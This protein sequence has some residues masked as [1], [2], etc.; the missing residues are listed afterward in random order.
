M[1]LSQMKIDEFLDRLASQAPTPGGGSVAALTGALAAGLGH[2]ACALTLGKPKFAAV[3][4]QLRLFAQRLARAGANLREL[5]DEDA[6]AYELLRAALSL[7]KGD[8]QRPERVQAAAWVAGTVPLETA[9]FCARVL[10]TVQELQAIGNPLLR[11]DM[12]A[13][14]HLAKA[15]ILAAV[16]NVRANLPLM[17]AES[18][19]FIEKQLASLPND[20]GP[21]A[22]R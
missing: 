4:P 12:Q 11:S 3:E 1:S 19:Q 5:I 22:G 9:E 17:S 6:A 2:M 10:D 15:A 14:T 13:A 18:A 21:A 8:P 7:D 16:A 20:R